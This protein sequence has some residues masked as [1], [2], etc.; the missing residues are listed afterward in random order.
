MASDAVYRKCSLIEMFL[1]ISQNSHEIL[2]LELLSNTIVGLKP[3]NLIKKDSRADNFHVSFAR[4]PI[5]VEHL[6]RI[7]SVV[8]YR[9]QLMRFYMIL[10]NVGKH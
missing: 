9:N 4:R 8:C 3:A 10:Q 6:Q 7:A 2:V 5:F 1:K